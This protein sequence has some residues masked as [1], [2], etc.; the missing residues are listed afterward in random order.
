M[1]FIYRVT[2]EKYDFNGFL[3]IDLEG[4]YVILRNRLVPLFHNIFQFEGQKCQELG[5]HTKTMR[6]NG[7]QTI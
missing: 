1:L 7:S 2:F 3:G 5:F 6:N 4:G